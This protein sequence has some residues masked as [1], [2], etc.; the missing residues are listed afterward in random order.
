M[1]KISF[2]IVTILSFLNGNLFAQDG[3]TKEDYSNYSVEMAD[4]LRSSG[5]IY[6]LVIIIM[7]VLIGLFLYL[8]KTEQRLKKIEKEI[9]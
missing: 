5:K 8:Y 3:I 2:I 7:I 1:N 4:G 6:V 9:K